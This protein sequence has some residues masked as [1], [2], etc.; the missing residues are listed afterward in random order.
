MSINIVKRKTIV[1]LISICMIGLLF[2]V[3]A[4]LAYTQADVDNQKRIA[5][6]KAA[7]AAQKQK[8]ATAVQNQISNLSNQINQMSAILNDTDQK[9]SDT[10]KQ[11]NDLNSEILEKENEIV[12]E[13]EK[14]DNVIVS[15][16]MEG[17]T[18]LIEAV[19]VSDT[20]SE[21]TSQKEY[22]DSIR[23]HIEIEIEKINQMKADLGDQKSEQNQQMAFL[24][25]L[26]NDQSS[27]KQTLQQDKQDH[28]QLLLNTKY[29]INDLN[30][31]ADEAASRAQEISWEIQKG[32]CEAGGGKWS[33][34]SHT[35]TGPAR[36]T[37]S[38]N[39]APPSMNMKYFSQNDS[40]W[41]V[42]TLGDNTST[43]DD[44]GCLITS[45]AMVATT[46]NP[47]ETPTT[48][49]SKSN[50][51]NGYFLGFKDSYV[52]GMGGL[53]NYE[54][55]SSASYSKIDSELGKRNPVI[56]YV[57][58][59]GTYGHWIVLTSGTRGSYTWYDPFDWS[60]FG[61]S[62]PNYNNYNFSRMRTFN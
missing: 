46:F 23:Q 44:I 29:A 61:Y 62:Q 55:Y 60:K 9:I 2:P 57:P 45:L 42:I 3:N 58:S 35:C 38:K 11:I 7:Q 8:D 49:I 20:I 32:Y 30:R 41:N 5:N 28:A 37:G 51:S 39:Y 15:W 1:A 19:L 18:S 12:T 34:Q 21:I 43:V 48:L 56:V 31:Q 33:S 36:G 59:I 53:V 47:S 25:D 13:K 10:Q 27:Q 14:L 50:F 6:E 24:T 22:K 16:Y 54:K 26:K 4:A 40:P 52:G 17:E